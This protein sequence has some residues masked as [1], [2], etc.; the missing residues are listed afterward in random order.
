MPTFT[1][2]ASYRDLPLAELA[3]AKLESE[4]IYCHL[5]DQYHIG[6]NW[7]YSNALGGIKVQVRTEDVAIANQILNEDLSSYVENHN[8]EFEPL[9]QDDLCDHCGSPNLELVKYSRL[10]AAL[11]LLTGLFLFF[12][13]TRYTCKDCGHKMKKV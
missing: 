7:L 3:K 4:G 13:G 9:D 6:I 5:L 8:D 11:M 2:I 1:T 12:W 10:S